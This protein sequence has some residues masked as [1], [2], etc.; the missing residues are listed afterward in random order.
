M[1]LGGPGGLEARKI[2]AAHH[3]AVHP[4]RKPCPY[5]QHAGD[6]RAVL[7]QP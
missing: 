7:D 5:E 4:R 2:A 3:V 6:R 1:H